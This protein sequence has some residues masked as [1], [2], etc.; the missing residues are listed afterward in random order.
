MNDLFG[1]PGRW[2]GLS[3]DAEGKTPAIRIHVLEANVDGLSDCIRKIVHRYEDL[4][5]EWDLRR[6]FGVDTMVRNEGVCG[7]YRVL[8]AE[9]VRS[10]AYRMSEQLSELFSI[11]SAYAALP[12][13]NCA[14]DAERRQLLRIQMGIRDGTDG[15]MAIAPIGGIAY[16][17]L[18]DWL[19]LQYTKK[20][21][22][23]LPKIEEMI[24]KAC[25]ALLTEKLPKRRGP[26]TF[27]SIETRIE[28]N[29]SF[30]L[31]T[32]GN[33]SDVST[34]EAWNRKAGEQHEIGCHNVDRPIQQLSLL[35]G[36]AGLH[37]IASKELDP[38]PP[39]S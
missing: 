37:D 6:G 3:F 27:S 17:E 21:S 35:A 26:S 16:A 12:D 4:L 30:M 36:L 31:Q 5:F 25:N 38:R 1:N 20:G 2:Y 33:T 7:S 32:I 8:R 29:G 10:R 24:W 11:L 14:F 22:R 28:D 23:R 9:L 39:D 19:A 34:Y 15:S 18:L 13:S